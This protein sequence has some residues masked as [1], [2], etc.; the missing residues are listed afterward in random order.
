MFNET[1]QTNKITIPITGMTCASCVASVEKAL[2]KVPGVLSVKVNPATEKASVEYLKDEAG[3]A[4][5]QQAVESAGYSVMAEKEKAILKIGGMTCASCAQTI[6]KALTKAEGVV[7]ANVNLATE[8]ATV[9]FDA[10][11]T[12]LSALEKVIEGI[13]YQVIKKEAGGKEAEKVDEDLLKVEKA[14]RRFLSAVIPT[15][16]LMI[17]MI[18]DF[19]AVMIPAHHEIMALLGFPV[20]F[21]SGWSTHRASFMAIRGGRANMDVLISLGSVPAYLIGVA[22]L[23][24]PAV[25][26]IE[27]STMVVT[28][29][30]LGRYLEVRAKGQAS[31]AIKKLLQLGAKTAHIQVD[32]EEKEIA[33]EDVKIGDIMVVRPGEKIPT[34]GVIVE[35]ESA[36]D[37]SMAT[38]ESMPVQKHAGDEVIGATI[39]QQGLLKVKAT[40]IG[41]DTF[42]SQMIKMVEECQGS[43]VPIQEFADRVTGYMVPAVLAVALTTVVAWLIFPG[44]FMN[45]ITWAEPFLPWINPDLGTVTLALFAGIAVLVISCPCA[46]GLATPTALMVGSGMGAEHG[47]LI[48]HGEAIQTMKDIHTIVFDKTGT[49]T[50]GKPAVTDILSGREFKEEDILYIAAS[51]EQGSEH[52][53]GQTLVREARERGNGLGEVTG[54]AAIPG[55]GVKGVVDSREVLVGNQKLMSDYGIDFSQFMDRLDR[56]EDEAKTAILVAIDS[57]IAGIIAVA[58]TLKEDSIQAIAELKEMGLETA[59]I[60]GDNRRTA[61]AIARKV[62]ITRVLAEVLPQD[63]VAEIQRLQDAVGMVAMVGDGINDAPALTQANVGIAIGTGTDIAIESSDIILVRGDLSSVVTTVKLSRATFRKIKQNYVWAW[64]YNGLAIPLAAIGLLHAMIGVA[65]MAMSS[66]NVI[67]NS[68]RLRKARIKPG[69]RQGG[70]G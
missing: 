36:I 66:V 23:I 64:F 7:E 46:L 68:L 62:G 24:P 40:R 61:E 19:M 45:I 39:N 3:M 25:S 50:H 1:R 15:A 34:D 69:R 56:L 17:L 16:V 14:R 8:Q 42:L 27:L 59:M 12:N 41:K 26:F 2:A 51:L 48:R 31:Q 11:V 44:F 49:I 37:E 54:F 21:L 67:T 35:G 33:I 63:K 29:H 4:D 10:G 20:V 43:K 70:K 58:D 57:E 9:E 38:G 13:G 65:A 28:F 52:P 6:E 60:T 53:L 5:F 55:K 47:V 18:L 22:V 30:L 32:G